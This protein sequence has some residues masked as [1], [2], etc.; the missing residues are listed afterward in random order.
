MEKKCCICGME[1]NGYGNNAEPI[2]KGTCCD[3]CNIR[4]VVAS[5]LFEPT[6]NVSFANATVRQL[7]EKNFNLRNASG[8]F[9]EWINEESGEIVFTPN[10]KWK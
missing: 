4:Y 6:D 7:R 3:D 10:L 5:R 2:A 8:I 9:V 1:F